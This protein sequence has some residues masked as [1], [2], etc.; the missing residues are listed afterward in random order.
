MVAQT[1]VFA[2]NATVQTQRLHR[3]I[4]VAGKA[5]TEQ[6]ALSIQQRAT[7][8]VKEQVSPGDRTV[9]DSPGCHTRQRQAGINS[10]IDGLAILLDPQTIHFKQAADVAVAHAIFEG[11]NPIIPAVIDRAGMGCL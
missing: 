6:A 11:V 4:I 2:R 1:N 5:Y 9:G 10:H 7:G 8:E 3:C